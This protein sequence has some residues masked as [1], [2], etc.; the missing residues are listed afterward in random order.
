[1]KQNLKDAFV[2]NDE[3]EFYSS[4]TENAGSWAPVL[5]SRLLPSVARLSNFQGSLFEVPPPGPLPRPSESELQG[6]HPGTGMFSQPPRFCSENVYL[7]P[8]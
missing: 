1:M 3:Q 7:G 4:V 5:C 8:T 6:W 2:V